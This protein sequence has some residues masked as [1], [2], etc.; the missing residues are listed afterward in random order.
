[1]IQKAIIPVAG[2]GTRR[3]PITKAVEKCMLPVLNRSKQS[4]HRIKCVSNLR[5]LGLATQM[6]W[7]DNGGNAFR[8]RLGAT[9]GGD[10]FWFGWLG[11]G[12][13]GERAFDPGQGVL[14][15]YLSGRGV[16][17]CPSLDYALRQF[18]LKAT[19]AAYGYGYNLQ[20]SA[21]AGQPP[22]SVNKLSHP[23]EIAVLADAA[24]VNTF[25]APASPE[26]PMV[27]EFYYVT[28]NEATVHFRHGRTAN[29]LSCDG[30]VSYHAPL[31]GSLDQRVPGEII[32]RLPSE[33][34]SP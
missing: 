13:E 16:D 17:L 19:G 33:S 4:A 32:G 21:P 11:W 3:L 29:V 14:S 8:Y 23:A 6:Y 26:R 25:Q 34:L 30:H 1:M 2:Y 7:D 27:E 22:L 28:T 15:V 24:Q 12:G 5:Q 9:N 18:K 20:L 10:L 31:A